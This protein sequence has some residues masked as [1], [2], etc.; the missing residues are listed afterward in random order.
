MAQPNPPIAHMVY[1]T[2]TDNSQAECARL[3]AACKTYLFDHPGVV[4]FSTGVR[5]E[6]FARD[7][8]DLEYDVHLTVVFQNKAAHDAYQIAPA[9]EQFIQ[10]CKGNWERV[11]VFDS[12]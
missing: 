7:V 12:V 10:E 5:S 9:H 1:F 4:Y 8:N 6:D 3:I 2:L 11:R